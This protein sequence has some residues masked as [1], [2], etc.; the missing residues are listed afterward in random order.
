MEDW[1]RL[2][3]KDNK[4]KQILDVPFNSNDFVLHLLKNNNP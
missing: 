4:I 3:Y 2:I 1:E